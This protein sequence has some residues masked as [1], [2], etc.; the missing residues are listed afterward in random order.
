M[1]TNDRKQWKRRNPAD[2][3]WTEFKIFFATS[4]QELRESQAT[5]TGAGYHAVNLVYHQSSNQVY[6]KETAD[7]IAN[8]ATA[9]ASNRASVATLTN[10]NHNLAAAITLTLSNNKLV[11][12]LQD[13]ARLTGTISELRRKKGYQSTATVPEVGW[14]K[15]HYCWTCGYAYEH[16]SCD[17]PSPATGHQKGANRAKRLSGSTKNR[18][19]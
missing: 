17:C 10:T 1:F 13:V 7:A 14:S 12:A 4:H 5:T 8:L 16:S 6:K 2:K 9:T 15:I 19:S 18:P 11:T 3:N